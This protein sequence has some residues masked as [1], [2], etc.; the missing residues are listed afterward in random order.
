MCARHGTANSEL[1]ACSNRRVDTGLQRAPN[2]LFR[3]PLPS[4]PQKETRP[5]EVFEKHSLFLLLLAVVG[6]PQAEIPTYHDQREADW[7]APDFL[8][9]TGEKLAELRLLIGDN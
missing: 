8:F 5:Y 9:H 2:Q 3:L 4:A 6:S 7:V 1:K